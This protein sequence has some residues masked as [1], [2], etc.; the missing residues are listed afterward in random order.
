[1][2]VEI[3]GQRE[4]R[5]WRQEKGFASRDLVQTSIFSKPVGKVHFR[6]KYRQLLA[7]VGWVRQ[8]GHSV[9]VGR[10]SGRREGRV[11]G[12]FWTYVY[13]KLI[14]ESKRHHS[15]CAA[16]HVEL[17]IGL[18]TQGFISFVQPQIT[19]ETFLDVWCWYVLVACRTS[20]TWFM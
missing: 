9:G 3:W 17:H 11:E 1:M 20:P 15:V 19:M 14:S 7:G 8:W 4:E 13:V 6:T 16:N 10:G 5:K 12:V 18:H 2:S